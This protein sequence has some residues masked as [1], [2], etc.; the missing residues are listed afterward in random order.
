MTAIHPERPAFQA[1]QDWAAADVR[2]HDDRNF[3][4]LVN[5]DL[6]DPK[7]VG[8]QYAILRRKENRVRW[9]QMLVSIQQSIIQQN[10][11][12]N[13]TLKSHPDR[14]APGEL[15]PQSYLDAKREIEERKRPRERALRAVNERLGEARR[16]I[17][18]DPISSSTAGRLVAYLADVDL[19]LASG[20]TDEA[21]RKVR[22][23]MW[24][25]GSGGA[26]VE[27]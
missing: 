25:L 17:G 14:P 8:P 15:T 4:R 23:L 7:G 16:L 22:S 5:A 21:R 13:A 24:I 11:L 19:L 20:E 26:E 12:A 10:A 27:S 3:E 1:P 9:L 6:R 2:W 18:S